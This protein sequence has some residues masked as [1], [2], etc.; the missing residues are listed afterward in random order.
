M[1]NLE[2]QEL[3][4]KGIKEMKKVFKL[5]LDKETR[6]KMKIKEAITGEKYQDKIRKF[7][8]E[9]LKNESEKNT[10]NN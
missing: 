7:I 8:T 3:L 2:G 1:E 6:K 5:Y 9:D 10:S 4:L